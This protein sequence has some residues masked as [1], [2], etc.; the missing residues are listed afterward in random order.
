MRKVKSFLIRLEQ[1]RVW[2]RNEFRLLGPNKIEDFVVQFEIVEGKKHLTPVRYDMKH[3]YFHRD[4]IDQNGN[5]VD[6][7]KIAAASLEDAVKLFVDDL[8]KNWESLL[9]MGG[10]TKLISSFKSFPE[11]IMQKAKE[12][13]VDLIRNP[14]KIDNAPN[15]VNL[16]LSEGM[17]ISNSVKVKLIREKQHP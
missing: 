6:K 1:E 3:N 8:I 10:Y 5:I 2:F 16:V 17:S 12:Y 9:K 15:I 11:N 7:E 14:Q 4:V 13:L